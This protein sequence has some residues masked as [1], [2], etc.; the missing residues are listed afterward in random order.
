MRYEISRSLCVTIS[1]SDAVSS[2][3]VKNIAATLPVK[4][5]SSMDYECI[6]S[7]PAQELHNLLRVIVRQ[8]QW[9]PDKTHTVQYYLDDKVWNDRN[10]QPRN[11]ST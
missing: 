1:V 8:V 9:M 11:G 5:A 7:S 6:C 2:S 10:D 4:S 3:R